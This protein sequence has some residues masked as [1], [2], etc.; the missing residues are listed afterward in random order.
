MLCLPKHLPFLK[1]IFHCQK[2]Q[3]LIQSHFVKCKQAIAQIFETCSE[4]IDHIVNYEK[5]VVEIFCV[6]FYSDYFV[7][8]LRIVQFLDSQ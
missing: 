4:M 1:F 2:N 8:I 5:T 7:W 3:I 6:F